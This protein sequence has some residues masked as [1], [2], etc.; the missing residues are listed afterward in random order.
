MRPSSFS[1]SVG[2]ITYVSISLGMESPYSLYDP[3]SEFAVL[4]RSMQRQLSTL[5]PRPLNVQA[6][7]ISSSAARSWRAQL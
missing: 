1:G 4:F 6:A 5:G 2:P 7:A 3:K